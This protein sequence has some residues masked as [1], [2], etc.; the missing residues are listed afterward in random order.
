MIQ[1]STISMAEVHMLQQNHSMPKVKS[2]EGNLEVL[3]M[4][5]FFFIDCV[6]FIPRSRFWIWS[7]FW[8]FL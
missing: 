8:H 3:L 6:K 1:S 5:D 4:W 2:S 7:L